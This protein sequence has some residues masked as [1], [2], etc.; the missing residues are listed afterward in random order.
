MIKR[1]F[2]DRVD[3]F[4]DNLAINQRIENPAKITPNTAKT[5]PAVTYLAKMGT[6]LAND[7]VLGQFGIKERFFHAGIITA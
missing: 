2:F 3:R 5:D 7:F 4:G 1:L 6:E